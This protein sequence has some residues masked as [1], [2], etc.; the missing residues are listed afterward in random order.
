MSGEELRAMPGRGSDWQ[1]TVACWRGLSESDFV[2]VRR[3]R[4]VREV[5]VQYPVP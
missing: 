4:R 5:K 2:H 1:A 3:A